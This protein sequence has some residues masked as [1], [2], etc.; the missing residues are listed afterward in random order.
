MT[1]RFQEFPRS[2]RWSQGGIG[3]A[4]LA[5]AV[6]GV[7]LRI[8]PANIRT[9]ILCCLGL[10]VTGCLLLSHYVIVRYPYIS[11]VEPHDDDPFSKHFPSTG[12]R[13]Y[14]FLKLIGLLVPFL[15]ALAIWA[16]GFQDAASK[17]TFSYCILSFL[18][19]VYFTFA[20]DSVQ[21]PTVA[22]FV[23]STLGLGIPLYP[24]YIL[25]IAIGA[26]R[27][28]YLLKSQL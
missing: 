7:L 19:M 20:Y 23:R 26:F 24:F 25:T 10:L 6:G 15:I 21:H 4:L 14:M 17:L 5:L 1:I 8:A 3:F 16:T 2:Y 28:R 18:F 11:L 27:C 22:T 9:L 13:L 12:S